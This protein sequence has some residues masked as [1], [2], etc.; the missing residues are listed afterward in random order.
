MTKNDL[1]NLLPQKQPFLFV[2]EILFV[3][4]H[5]I[6][7]RHHFKGNEFFYIGHFPNMPLTPGVIL[8]EA[9]CQVG[10]S[11]HS[12]YLKS[13]EPQPVSLEK[14]KMFLTET[15]IE[16]LLPVPPGSKIEI[17]GNKQFFRFG[18]IKSTIEMYLN[19]KIVAQG[20]ASG[21]IVNNA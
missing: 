21:M 12:I 10:I 15:N 6:I 13:L 17:I 1:I 7:G 19:D 20:N 11:A 18:K 9:M 3:N 16:F 2:D 8:T 4:E 14:N 5:Q